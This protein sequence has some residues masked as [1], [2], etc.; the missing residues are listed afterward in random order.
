MNFIPGWSPGFLASKTALSSITQVLSATS[1]GS[2]IN[3]PG[4]IQ[5]GDL[6]VFLDVCFASAFQPTPTS[7]TPT[8]FTSAQDVNGGGSASPFTPG[9]MTLWYKLAIG[10]ES[11]A[12]TGMNNTTMYKTMYVFRGNA[13]ATALTM[14]GNGGNLTDGN[15]T[16]VVVGANAGVAPLVVLG[17]YCSSGTVDPRTFSTTKDGEINANV[18]SYLAYKIYNSGPA[19]TSIDMDDEGATNG[20][21]GC[22][23][24]MAN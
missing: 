19:S 18:R 11:G 20:V 5:A 23:I 7:V 13:P 22:Y 21:L 24:Q 14:A 12:L 3:F 2:T 17:G 4:G 10:S 1:T 16:A 6:I 8:G 15:P 9:R